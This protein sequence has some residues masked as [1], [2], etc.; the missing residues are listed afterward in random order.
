M[1][2]DREV[3]Q[4]S[5]LV[6]TQLRLII[7]PT[8]QCNFRCKY[9]YE[10]F[11]LREM[12][13]GVVQGI[14]NLL[15]TRGPELRFLSI[16][17]FGGEPLLSYGLITNIMSFITNEMP[18]AEQLQIESEMTTNGYLLSLEKFKTLVSLGVREY[19]ITFDGDQAEH[20]RLRVTAGEAPTF[21]KIWRNLVDAHGTDLDSSV[22]VRIH[23]NGDNEDSIGIFIERFSKDIGTDGRF[24]LFIRGL[25]R[26]GGPNDHLLPIIRG[27]EL[28]TT[29]DRL[30]A[31][32]NRLGLCAISEDYWARDGLLV[33]YASMWNSFMIRPDGRIGKCT[34]ALRDERNTVGRINEDG[35][36]VL[37]GQK[38]AWWA[39]GTFSRDPAELA[40][41]LAAASRISTQVR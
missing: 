2:K 35:T 15:R 23:V 25:S 5:D 12:A 17:W 22:I 27:R 16:S 29:V 19:Q 38:L 6:N 8:E 20:D 39:R 10:D 32:A 34:V 31:K 33:C 40:C 4:T 30:R 41:P 21:S 28:Q 1:Y 36:L 18:H 24:K 11:K 14:K 7:L 3:R 26:L 9:C 13:P 37:D